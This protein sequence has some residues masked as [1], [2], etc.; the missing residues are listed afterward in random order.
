MMI[1][2]MEEGEIA[3]E[4]SFKHRYPYDLRKGICRKG[5]P[6]C[7]SAQSWLISTFTDPDG[8]CMCVRVLAP[9]CRLRLPRGSGRA[10]GGRER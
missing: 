5:T 7:L 4:V 8:P 3:V 9:T 2:A 6:S 10:E 1:R